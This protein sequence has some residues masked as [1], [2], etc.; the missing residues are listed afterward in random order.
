MTK[1]SSGSAL[2]GH[3]GTNHHQG[4]SPSKPFTSKDKNPEERLRLIREKQE[5]ELERRKRELEENLKRKQEFWFKQQREKQKRLEESK[6][7]E[8]EKHLAC[9]ER[10]K[11]REEIERVIIELNLSI[12]LGGDRTPSA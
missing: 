5:Q 11:K 3:N 7:R 6:L 4:H 9:E 1:S 10:R 2:S 8:N 12:S